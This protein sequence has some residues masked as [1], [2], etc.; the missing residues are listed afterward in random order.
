MTTT[1]EKTTPTRA[2]GRRKEATA[3]VRLV[4]GETGVTVNGKPV[5]KHFPYRIHQALIVEPLKLVGMQDSF[6]VSAKVEGG[7]LTGQAEAIRH[8]IARALVS[9]NAEFR[10]SLKAVGFLRRDPRSKERKKPGLRRARRA[11]QW[12]KR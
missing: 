6:A 4:S 9:L 1:A 12:S 5:E 7:G 2:V 3:R 8:G 11:P 10:K